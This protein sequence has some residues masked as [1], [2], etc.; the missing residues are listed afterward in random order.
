MTED[1]QVPQPFKPISLPP[2]QI[3]KEGIK[4][5]RKK[6]DLIHRSS[7]GKEPIKIEGQRIEFFIPDITFVVSELFPPWHTSILL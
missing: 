6:T 7:W 4:G 3:E 5:K 1:R 2:N